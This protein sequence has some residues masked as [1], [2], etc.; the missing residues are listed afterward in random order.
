[1]STVE[2]PATSGSS[3]ATTVVAVE[4]A[5]PA[6]ANKAKK[7]GRLTYWIAM[8]WLIVLAFHAVFA[9][10]LP[11]VQDYAKQD[12]LSG[13]SAPT[14]LFWDSTEDKV[15]WMG[16]D[17][18][19][20]DI[21]SRC[22][23]GARISLAIGAVSTVMG[24]GFGALFG[25]VSGFYRGKVDL[26]IDTIMNIILA[27]PAL[28]LALLLITIGS[29]TAATEEADRVISVF[30]LFDLSLSRPLLVIT[31]LSF[32]SIPPLTRLVRANTMVYSQ[33]EFVTAARALGASNRRLIFREIL[34]NVVPTMLTFALTALAILIIAEGALAFLGL[35]VRP[36]QP[37]WGS[38][39]DAG[40]Q[41]LENAW[42]ISL[43]PAAVMFCTV[44]AINLIGDVLGNRFNVKESVG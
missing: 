7:R 14:W 1:M 33:R 11:W 10:F 9:D 4:P 3:D 22:V 27:F 16:T 32:L 19:G 44:L 28:I 30:G 21:F 13:N 17:R 15:G 36:P 29:N 8:T 41:S 35:S 40:R 37:T 25:L 6:K 26:V 2:A 43:M 20:R 34:P 12:V 42:W 31:A 38:M 23:Y 39:I 18:N 24:L 5:A